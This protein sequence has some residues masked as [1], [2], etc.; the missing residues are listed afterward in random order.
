MPYADMRNVVLVMNRSHDA[1]KTLREL[2]PIRFI[3]SQF[4]V[5]HR[6]PSIIDDDVPQRQPMTFERLDAC[7][8]LL[9]G[10]L[11]IVGVPRAPAQRPKGLRV[12]FLPPQPPVITVRGKSGGIGVSRQLIGVA[13]GGICKERNATRR[14]FWVVA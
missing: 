6:Q 14:E 3:A 2:P 4:L 1:P 7:Q 9:R 5:V 13:A 10:D 8:Q 12:R 11:L